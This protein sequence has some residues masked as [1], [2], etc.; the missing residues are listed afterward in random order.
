MFYTIYSDYFVFLFLIRFSHKIRPNKEDICKKRI[1]TSEN[2]FLFKYKN[3]FYKT[4]LVQ[5]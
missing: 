4:T 5:L 3:N 2:S 1:Y